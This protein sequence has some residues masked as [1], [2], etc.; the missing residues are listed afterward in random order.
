MPP[1][2]AAEISRLGLDQPLDARVAS[3]VPSVGPPSSHR[4]ARPWSL[5]LTPLNPLNP[6]A[7]SD[8]IPGL[9]FSAKVD[10]PSGNRNQPSAEHLG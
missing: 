8:L 5:V 6:S 10:T 9:R 4:A 1:E 2:L 3:V 7:F